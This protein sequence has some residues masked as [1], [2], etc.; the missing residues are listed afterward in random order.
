VNGKRGDPEANE[1]VIHARVVGELIPKGDGVMK[2]Y[3][4]NPEKTAETIKNG[5]LHTGDMVKMDRVGFI[6][7]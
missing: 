4:K 7:I 1:G 3:Y 5:W 6:K 2:E